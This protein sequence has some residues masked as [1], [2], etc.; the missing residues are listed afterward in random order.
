MDHNYHAKTDESN[1]LVGE[2][3]S[4]YRMMIGS[5]NWLITLDRYNMH[6]TTTTL[7]RHLML[8]HQGHMHA[9]K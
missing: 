8:P 6:Y 3:I 7:A 5:L 2:E 4:K 1:F 9:M